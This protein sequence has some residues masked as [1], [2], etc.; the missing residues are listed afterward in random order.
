[1]S[2]STLDDDDLFGEAAN[3]MRSDVEEHL[4]A[5]R[6]E[7]P[8]PDAIW[9]VE[10]D[11]TLG[12]LNAL[13][14]ELDP[15]EAETHLRDAKKWYTMGERADAFDDAGDLEDEIDAVEGVITDL[16][17]AREQVSDLAGTVPEIRSALESAD[18]E[19]ESDE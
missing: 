8:D 2:Q 19:S 15:G 3:E 9:D 16:S 10:A 14:S 7:L 12:V 18:E 17:A 5:A 11:N 13:R 4:E 1:M 6:D